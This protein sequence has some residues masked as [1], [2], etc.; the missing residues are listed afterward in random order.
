MFPTRPSLSTC[1]AGGK[2]SVECVDVVT[3]FRNK[4]QKIAE[5]IGFLQRL[6]SRFERRSTAKMYGRS[7]LEDSRVLGN[8]CPGLL[9]NP[10]H[11]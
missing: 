9:E 6:M 7:Y 4:L 3:V 2:D 11:G 10:S 5:D 1:S 8:S